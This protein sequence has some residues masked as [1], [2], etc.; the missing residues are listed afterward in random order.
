MKRF[1]LFI[2]LALFSFS[3]LATALSWNAYNDTGLPAGTA[4]AAADYHIQAQCKVNTG[5]Y[6]TAGEVNAST[7]SMTITPT[8]SPGDALTCQIRALRLSDNSNST[9]SPE[10]V[11][12]APLDVPI[13]P[14]G[15]KIQF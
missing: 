7:N 15:L 5:A 12:H 14:A 3:A 4:Y 9:W 2:S 1:F 6:A 10:V 11:A 13:P 8:L